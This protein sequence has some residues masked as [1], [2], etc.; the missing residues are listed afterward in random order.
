MKILYMG[1]GRLQTKKVLLAC[2]FLI[3][4]TA[5]RSTGSLVVIM[6]M[7]YTIHKLI[8]NSLDLNVGKEPP[9]GCW[10]WYWHVL[11]GM[12]YIFYMF[13]FLVTIAAV[14]LFVIAIWKPYE[15]YCLSRLDTSH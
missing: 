12:K 13:V 7:F 10:G 2:V 14:P 5:V 15:M 11:K 6:P 9:S 1:N 4:A 8:R 3:L